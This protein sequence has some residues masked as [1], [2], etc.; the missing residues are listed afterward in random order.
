[1]ELHP[2]NKVALPSSPISHHYELQPILRSPR[3]Q[4]KT[5]MVTSSGG[6]TFRTLGNWD[7]P[8]FTLSWQNQAVLI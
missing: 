3:Q 5:L 6:D 2:G 8:T 1:M 7:Y 4:P